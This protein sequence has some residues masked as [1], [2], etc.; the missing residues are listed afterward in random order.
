MEVFFFDGGCF[1]K[2]TDSK[3]ELVVVKMVVWLV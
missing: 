2:V 3:I 1:W